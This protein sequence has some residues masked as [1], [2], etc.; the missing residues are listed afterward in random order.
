M[1][2]FHVRGSAQQ[3]SGSARPEAELAELLG[4]VLATHSDRF[5]ETAAAFAD[6]AGRAR[7]DD[8][9]SFGLDRI[10]DGVATLIAE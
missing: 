10:L 8:A 4:P 9:F 1:L 7:R 2:T 3:G 6:P 5:P